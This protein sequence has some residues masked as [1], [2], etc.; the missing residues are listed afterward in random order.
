MTTT[1]TTPTIA[2]APKP[3]GVHKPNS[4][5][6]AKTFKRAPAA[7]ILKQLANGVEPSAIAKRLRVHVST[8]YYYRKQNAKTKGNAALRDKKREFGKAKRGAA[9]T[10][11]IVYLQHAQDAGAPELRRVSNEALLIEL[12]LRRLDGR[13]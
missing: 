9:I 11:A 5:D 2:S 8:V 7:L 3:N 10:D 12:G 1:T 6:P 4:D 13:M